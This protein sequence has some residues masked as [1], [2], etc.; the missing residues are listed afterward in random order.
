MCVPYITGCSDV[1]TLIVL[2][3]LLLLYEDM[4]DG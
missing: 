3:P 1:L 4:P 2:L